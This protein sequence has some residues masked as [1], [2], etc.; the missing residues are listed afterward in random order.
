MIRLILFVSL[1]LC[2]LIAFSQDVLKPIPYSQIEGYAD[3]YQPEFINGD[4]EEPP[5]DYYKINIVRFEL[6]RNKRWW[7]RYA[8]VLSVVVKNG[9]LTFNE[10][11]PTIDKSTDENN[12]VI[13]SKTIINKPV[14]GWVPYNGSDVNL[15]I[16]L[17]PVQYK[18]NVKE[19]INTIVTIGNAVGENNA[20]LINSV[21][22][23]SSVANAVNNQLNDLVR[24]S[25]IK[26]EINYETTLE[27]VLTADDLNLKFR[28]GF[29]ILSSGE[30]D[31]DPKSV[32]IDRQGNVTINNK[33]DS[34]YSYV[35]IRISRTTERKG[36]QNY[37]FY[38]NLVD[39]STALSNGD[40]DE[41]DRNLVEF[42]SLFFNSSDFTYN[43]KKDVWKEKYL[44]F[45]KKAKRISSSYQLKHYFFDS[46][47]EI[48]RIFDTIGSRNSEAVVAEIDKQ[49]VKLVLQNYF[50]Y[51]KGKDHV[52]DNLEELLLL[53]Q[54]SS[55]VDKNNIDLMLN[56][57]F[58]IQFDNHQLE[59]YIIKSDNTINSFYNPDVMRFEN[60]LNQY[61]IQVE[62]NQ[63]E[64]F[65]NIFENKDF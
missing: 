18:D 42:R 2:S 3:D 41:M 43:M 31:I 4:I 26:D 46:N 52:S 23:F 12:G 45:A 55:E 5:V 54:N 21:N 19:S 63:L 20:N 51:E 56:E 24:K 32:E 57:D 13:K 1:M 25:G 60:L 39:A 49:A 58:Q 62:P 40:L 48:I 9:D 44:H 7:K 53:Y 27:H 34:E 15:S 33:L 64:Q 14:T 61:S 37:S 17:F 10:V 6:G 30:A 50:K 8:P 28:E 38:S 59:E 35:I 22:I 65:K 16:S 36:L 47:D 29:Y 11:I